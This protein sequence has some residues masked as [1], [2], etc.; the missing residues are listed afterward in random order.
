MAW[1]GSDLTNGLIVHVRLPLPS[2]VRIIPFVYQNLNWAQDLILTKSDAL[3]WANE[4]TTGGLIIVELSTR[5]LDRIRWQCQP[6]LKVSGLYFNYTKSRPL[7]RDT[8]L[9]LML[10]TLHDI[11]GSIALGHHDNQSSDGN[12]GWRTL[13]NRVSIRVWSLTSWFC[14]TTTEMIRYYRGGGRGWTA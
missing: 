5:P 1:L 12:R 3:G 7:R 14:V 6:Q 13:K 2:Q 9:A 4:D 8:S 11:G 10:S